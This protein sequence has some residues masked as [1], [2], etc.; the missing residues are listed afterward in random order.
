[1]GARAGHARG[2]AHRRRGTVRAVDRPYRR[3]RTRRPHLDR[4][5]RDLGGRRERLAQPPAELLLRRPPASLTPAAPDH[6]R[7]DRPPR[8]RRRTGGRLMGLLARE[9]A[10]LVV[11]DV[12]EGFR[13]YETFASV[14]SAC[15]KLLSAARILE[16]PAIISEQ[17]PKGLGHTAPEVG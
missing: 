2:A 17:Y 12:Q 1:G 7:R 14:A 5:R 3:G 6:R 15:G 4:P 16:L 10:T 9:R 13:G 11:V 8:A